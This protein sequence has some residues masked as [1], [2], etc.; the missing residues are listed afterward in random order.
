MSPAIEFGVGCRTRDSLGRQ[1]HVFPRVQLVGV[2]VL[3]VQVLAHGFG[4]E[5]RLADVAEVPGQVDGL[6]CRGEP[7]P[8]LRWRTNCRGPVGAWGLSIASSIA[9]HHVALG[10][11]LNHNEPGDLASKWDRVDM[12][13]ICLVKTKLLDN[14]R[15]IFRIIIHF[16]LVLANALY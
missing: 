14:E 16:Q 12:E 13:T 5:L 15:K 6:T 1:Q 4:G 8:R 2:R 7:A 11:T 9:L 3:P 10:A